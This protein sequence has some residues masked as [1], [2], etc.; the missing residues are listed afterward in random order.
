MLVKNETVGRY[1][2]SYLSEKIGWVEYND[3]LYGFE[4]HE[5]FLNNIYSRETVYGVPLKFKEQGLKKYKIEGDEIPLNEDKTV[6]LYCQKSGVENM[7]DKNIWFVFYDKDV[8]AEVTEM[9]KAIQKM[10][11][12]Y[13]CIESS[14]EIDDAYIKFFDNILDIKL[15]EI[16]TIIR[17][18][19]EE[20]ERYKDYIEMSKREIEK[21]LK[22]KQEAEAN[23]KKPKHITEELDNI[24]MHKLTESVCYSVQKNELHIYT[25]TLYM[26]HPYNKSD[27]R[28]LGRMKI[29]INLENYNVLFENLDERR[30]SYWGEDCHHPHV[31]QSGEPCLGN[32]SSMIA[33]CQQTSSLYAVYLLC[34]NFLQTFEPEDPAGEYYVC[35]DRVDEEG[36]IVEVGQ[37]DK[38]TRYCTNCGDGIHEDDIY[39]CEECQE[40]VCPDCVVYVEDVYL[41]PECAENNTT[42]CED[43]GERHYNDVMYTDC[44]GRSICINCKE[45][46][47]VTCANCED[48]VHADEAIYDYDTELYYCPE[49]APTRREE[50]SDV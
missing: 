23:Y 24:K 41:C 12:K 7:T 38:Y 32:M 39:W 44:N 22:R 49:C 40:A 20:I 6:I 19:N 2:A 15:K 18:Y 17:R 14:K 34:L 30:T 48:Y 35:W 4:P 21:Q 13:F 25:K 16:N 26:R 37:D 3:G 46:H 43:C 9:Y 8:Y 50:R 5:G 31:E 11:Q 36:N 27:R 10:E 45:D 1:V 28:L 33:E 29:R 42:V 47:Y